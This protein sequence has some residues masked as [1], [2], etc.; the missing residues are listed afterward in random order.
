MHALKVESWCW[1]GVVVIFVLARL[2]SRTMLLGS[3]K[4][5]QIDDY[6]MT[7]ALC[8]YTALVVT[9]NISADCVSNLIDPSLVPALS[10]QEIRDRQ[11]GSKMGLTVEQLQCGTLWIVKA[12]LLFMYGRLTMSLKQ[13]V[14]VKWVAGYTAFSFVLMEILYYG[15]WCRP[16][17]GYWMVPAPSS[18]YKCGPSLSDSN[19]LIVQCSAVI[20]HLITQ[21]VLNIS[22]D[23][24]I[25]MI[26]MP[27]LIQAQLP[28]KRK[29]ILFAIFGLGFF[30]IL[31]AILTKVYSFTEPFGVNWVFWYIRESSTAIIVSNAPFTWTL[32]Q[33]MIPRLKS[34]AGRSTGEKYSVSRPGV[35]GTISGRNRNTYL[36]HKDH[37]STGATSRLDRDIERSETLSSQLEGCRKGRGAMISVVQT[38]R[39]STWEFLLQS[40]GGG[41]RL[42]SFVCHSYSRI[43]FLVL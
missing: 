38:I 7:F 21:A 15:V 30:E 35:S 25:I 9:L 42:V 33:R 4:R 8:T 27:L 29:V 5:L 22:S 16:F 14:A 31:C 11:Y 19:K 20:N 17:R 18:M 6:L 10:Q 23:L 24:L 34:F 32:L 2:V 26:P 40:P 13:N 43:T 36:Q 28:L 3:V 12:C 1:Y 37:P 41:S 39:A